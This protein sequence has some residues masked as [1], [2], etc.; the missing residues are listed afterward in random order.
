M[1]DVHSG[2]PPAKSRLRS[3]SMIVVIR[4]RRPRAAGSSGV[5]SWRRRDKNCG[6]PAKASV[7][8]STYGSIGF[9]ATYHQPRRS[10]LPDAPPLRNS[11]GDMRVWRLNIVAK[12]WLVEKPSVIA[13]SVI[14]RAGSARSFFAFSIFL[15]IT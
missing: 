5:L 8:T 4:A 6:S 12:Y 2:E 13:T 10:P 3:G 7:S 11:L 1:R 15:E 14:V 9:V